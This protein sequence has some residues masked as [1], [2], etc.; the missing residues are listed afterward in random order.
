MSTALFPSLWAMRPRELESLC[1][2]MTL[3][4][5]S[6]P[7]QAPEAARPM[8]LSSGQQDPGDLPFELVGTLAIIPVI[9]PM[10]KRGD[11]YLTSMRRIGQIVQLAASN[12]RVRAI[13]L[14]IDSPGGTVDGTE[15]L[16]GIIRSVAEE[17]PLYAYANGLMAS[18]AYWLGSCAKE[19]AAPSTAEIGSIGVVMVHTEA[20]RLAESIGYTFTVITAGKYKAMGNSV[21]P[22]SDEA[23]A[24][25]QSGIDG[26]YELFLEAVAT[27]RKVDRA[28]AL[29]MAD[30]KVFLAGEALS[31]GLIDRLESRESFIN[32]INEEVRMDLTTLKKEAPGALSEHRAE[33]EAELKVEASKKQQEAVAAERQRCVGVCGVLMGQETAQKLAGVLAAGVSVEQLTSMSALLGGSG[34]QAAPQDSPAKPD[35]QGQMLAALQNAHGQGMAPMAGKDV[36]E[37]SFEALVEARMAEA[38]CSKGA[39]IVHVART[40]PEAHQA[41]TNGLSRKEK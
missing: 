11:W 18:A 35:A 26:L 32:H 38:K 17:K 29:A 15:E 33:V 36:N 40:N 6:E 10:S 5:A 12:P 22:L 3:Q 27:G 37:T 23:R 34:S 25:L 28:G 41:Y 16:A 7:A 21:E 30:G 31:I 20:S 9:G 13:M 2:Q 39:A 19:I 8:G 24:Y 1:T 4:P 14:D